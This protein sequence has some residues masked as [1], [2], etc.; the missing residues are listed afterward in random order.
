MIRFIGTYRDRFGV[1]AI[2]RVLGATKSGFLT[3]R[4]YRAAKAR[5]PPARALSDEMFGAEITRL[6]GENYSVCGVRK[7]HALM[8]RQGWAIGRDQTAR[9]IAGP[10]T[11]RCPAQQAGVHH[12]AGPGRRQASRPG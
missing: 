5:P 3:A 2:C 11:A 8:R 6:H 4:A 1:E 9:L 7:M 12:R 10:R